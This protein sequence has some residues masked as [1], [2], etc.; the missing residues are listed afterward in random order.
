MPGDPSCETG[1]QALEQNSRA[2]FDEVDTG[3]S[4]KSNKM[5]PNK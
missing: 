1:M 2:F 3:S 4:N 5:R